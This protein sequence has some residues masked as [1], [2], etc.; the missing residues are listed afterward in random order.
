MF[1]DQKIKIDKMGKYISFYIT[2]GRAKFTDKMLDLFTN[3]PKPENTLCVYEVFGFDHNFY[4]Y[5]P[6]SKDRINVLKEGFKKYTNPKFK[7]VEII[8]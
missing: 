8:Y 7:Y 4:K 6:L 3:G 5:N 1:F 2:S